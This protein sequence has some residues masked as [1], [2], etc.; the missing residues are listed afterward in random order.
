MTVIEAEHAAHDAAFLDRGGRRAVA[1]YGRPAR[2]HTAVRRVV[3]V[4]E[5][6]HGVLVVEGDDRVEFVDNAVS[7]RV[8]HEDGAGCYALLCDPQGRIETDLHIYNAGERL[9][10][11]TPP[12]R[13]APVAE[14]GRAHV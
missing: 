6:A 2:G 11:F 12:E 13:A 9:L 10:L 4:I 3:G 5:H 1:D 7:N 8:P 14:I